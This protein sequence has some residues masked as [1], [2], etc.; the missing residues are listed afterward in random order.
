MANKKKN[1]DIKRT[2]SVCNRGLKRCFVDRSE[3]SYKGGID[4]KYIWLSDLRFINKTI[5]LPRLSCNRSQKYILQGINRVFP[6]IS[7][8][9][10]VEKLL[11]DWLF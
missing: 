7:C 11:F 9:A 2:E 4:Y 8:N 6:Q 1:E 5:V 10:N 3:I